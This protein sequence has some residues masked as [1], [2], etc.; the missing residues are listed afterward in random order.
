MPS[1]ARQ[2]WGAVNRGSNVV[3][4]GRAA[5]AA[6]FVQ[7]AEQVD[8][9]QRDRQR[10]V[11]AEPGGMPVDLEIERRLPRAGAGVAPGHPAQLALEAAPH[12]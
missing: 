5:A 7:A 8:R 9:E 3:T 12:P 11:I 4:S 1:D 6:P 10:A 2:V